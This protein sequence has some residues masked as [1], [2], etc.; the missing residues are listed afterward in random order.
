MV[1][2]SV[3]KS[4]GKFNDTSLAIPDCAANVPHDIPKQQIAVTFAGLIF[5]R[6][7]PRRLLH[8]IRRITLP[9]ALFDRG[10]FVVVFFAFC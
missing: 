6:A 4:R 7:T 9:F 8:S 10:A 1:P 3:P 2:R 5:P